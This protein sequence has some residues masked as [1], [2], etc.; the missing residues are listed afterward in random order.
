MHVAL[1][2]F[3]LIL[4]VFLTTSIAAADRKPSRQVV[5][6]NEATADEADHLKRGEYAKALKIANRTID[7]MVD[8]L[9]PGQAAT[10]LFG[11]VLT[12][13]ALAHAGLG[14]NDKA[15]W[16]WQT[17]LNLY[18]KF[19]E[20]DMSMFGAPGV[21]LK[22]NV[23]P[24][25]VPVLD[26]PPQGELRKPDV[27]RTVKPKYPRGAYLFGESGPLLVRV[28]VTPDGVAHSPHLMTRLPAPTLTY[29]ALEAI[30]QW[31]FEPARIGTTPIHMPFHV[32][33]TY[34]PSGL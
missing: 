7:E 16:Y 26:P 33:I 34:K 29:V 31:K 25:N 4:I 14:E 20:S 2:L 9:G 1:S 5:R 13:K 22:A 27:R 24:P 3:R 28:I 23:Q 19:A 6:W 11:I 30:R 21:L 12:H 18:P 8:M 32:T 10:E 15:L 17:V